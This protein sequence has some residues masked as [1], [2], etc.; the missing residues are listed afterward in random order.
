MGKLP[1]SFL[2]WSSDKYPLNVFIV[3]VSTRC[4]AG[5]SWD[6]LINT[7]SKGIKKNPEMLI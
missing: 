4:Q 6:H 3:V 1:V 5:F 7:E 2:Q